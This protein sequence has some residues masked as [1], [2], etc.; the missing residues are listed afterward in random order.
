MDDVR[1]K[2]LTPSK[3]F[4]KLDFPTF[5]RPRNATS[6]SPP[7]GQWVSSNALLTNSVLVIFMKDSERRIVSRE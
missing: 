2:P 1:A 5:D 3:E 6:G 4:I 7:A